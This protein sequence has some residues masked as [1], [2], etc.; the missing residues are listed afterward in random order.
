MRYVSEASGDNDDNDITDSAFSYISRAV[1]R[2]GF[3]RK[4]NLLPE[5]PGSS[6]GTA[7]ATFDDRRPR[8]ALAWRPS[9]RRACRRRGSSHLRSGPGD[10]RPYLASIWKG[11]L[12][13]SGTRRLFG[14]EINGELKDL[15]GSRASAEELQAAVVAHGGTAVIFEHTAAEVEARTREAAD[16]ELMGL[17][18]QYYVA[19][20][21][22]AWA[23]LLPVCGNLYHHSIEMSLMGICSSL[24]A[25][26]EKM[27]RIT[28]PPPW[29][30]EPVS[31]ERRL[32]AY[33]D[34]LGWRDIIARSISPPWWHGDRVGEKPWRGPWQPSHR[35]CDRN[36]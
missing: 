12:M 24:L 33:F 9:Q 21:A 19:A 14:V 13:V 25:E 2:G 32:L 5:L 8:R 18:V 30:C 31:Y 4:S 11:S 17:G 10:P 7:D 22:A 27:G 28:T 6:G 36:S 23:G 34:V 1:P 16:H 35:P 3:V 15:F 26:D 20:R 29:S